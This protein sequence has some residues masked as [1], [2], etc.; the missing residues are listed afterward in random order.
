MVAWPCL[1]PADII[2]ISFFITY[3]TV[4][5]TVLGLSGVCSTASDPSVTELIT[6]RTAAPT[7]ASSVASPD[8]SRPS[9]TN[10]TTAPYLFMEPF[11]GRAELSAGEPAASS[12]RSALTRGERM[13]AAQQQQQQQEQQQPTRQQQPTPTRAVAKKAPTPHSTPPSP[14]TAA[15]PLLQGG[16]LAQPTHIESPRGWCKL[17]RAKAA[18]PPVIMS[19][20]GPRD[21]KKWQ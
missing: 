5:H 16:E 12:V 18:V 2:I 9:H 15:P 11:T 17:A 10:S 1:S 6:Q 21:P 13:V 20:I 7:Y 19:I 4:R 14:A 8:L 3:W